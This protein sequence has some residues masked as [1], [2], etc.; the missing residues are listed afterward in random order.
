MGYSAITLILHR[1]NFAASSISAG[2]LSSI[3]KLTCCSN[4]CRNR[5]MFALRGI[6]VSSNQELGVKLFE[7]TFKVLYFPHKTWW[8]MDIR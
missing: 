2:E 6:P 8:T 1:N 4:L 3:F 7:E 5:V